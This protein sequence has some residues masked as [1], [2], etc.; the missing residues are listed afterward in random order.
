SATAR[1]FLSAF[2]SKVAPSSTIL[3]LSGPAPTSP[4]VLI[5]I[6]RP[7]RSARSSSI[8]PR[9]VVAT[10]SVCTMGPLTRAS[11]GASVS[12]VFVSESE[13]ETGTE[14]ETGAETETVS[15]DQKR[16]E[17]DL[18]RREG[19]ALDF[20]ERLDAREGQVDHRVDRLARNGLSFGSSLD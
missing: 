2:S 17:I 18:R 1:A 19:R 10:T 9:F 12:A 8:F 5:S 6:G 13:T 4:M 16:V 15:G 3:T 11:I 7:S 14:T 20:G